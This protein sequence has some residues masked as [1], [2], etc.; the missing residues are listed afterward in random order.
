MVYPGQGRYRNNAP[1]AGKGHEKAPPDGV[2]GGAKGRAGMDM[3]SHR[4]KPELIDDGMT[5]I[6]R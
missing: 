3:A 6:C 1:R 4:I 2:R 5:G